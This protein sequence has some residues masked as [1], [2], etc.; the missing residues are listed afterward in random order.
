MYG[1]LYVVGDDYNDTV[2]ISYSK[3]CVDNFR[4]L[5]VTDMDPKMTQMQGLLGL[6]PDDPSN[7]PSYVAAL[8]S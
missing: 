1:P 2:C 3:Q 7:G 8:W 4:F 5:A 6:A